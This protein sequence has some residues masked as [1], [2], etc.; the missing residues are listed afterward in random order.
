MKIDRLIAI[1]SVLLQKEK[2]SAAYLAEKF[3]VS[4]RTI[5]RDIESLSQAGI[6]IVTTQGKYGG[7]S[8][9]K[10]YKMERTLLSFADMQDVL[11]GLSGLD[12]VWGTNRYRQFKEKL[13]SPGKG[14]AAAKGHIFIDLASWYKASLAPKL[15]LIQNAVEKRQLITFTYYSPQTEEVRVIEPYLLVFQW[16][17]WYVWGYCEKRKD[18]RLFKLNRMTQVKLEEKSFSPR[19]YPPVTIAPEQVFPMR[20]MVK[21]LISPRMKWRL[22]EE[23]GVDSFQLREDGWCVFQFGFSDKENLFSW[24]LSFGDQAQLLEPRALRQEFYQMLQRTCD[25]YKERK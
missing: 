5:S 17:A 2:V 7:I 21:A 25:N 3:E 23:F 18:Y 10:E 8:I 11:A 20:M 6:P 16:A 1:L 19:E 24:L 13:F 22:V 15:A 4:R 14:D 9:I 12:S